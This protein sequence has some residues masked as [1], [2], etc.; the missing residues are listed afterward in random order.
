MRK[1]GGRRKSDAG[2][3]VGVGVEKGG[4]V[5]MVTMVILKIYNSFP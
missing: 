3:N 5:A 4:C 2:E 1:R